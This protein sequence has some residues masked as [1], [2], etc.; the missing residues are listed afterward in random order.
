M[1]QWALSGTPDAPE[2]TSRDGEPDDKNGGLVVNGDS[3]QTLQET[4]DREE[5]LPFSAKSFR[6]SPT[7]TAFT[8]GVADGTERFILDK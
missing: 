4:L 2:T 8:A 5:A 7:N 3:E 1:A 6:C